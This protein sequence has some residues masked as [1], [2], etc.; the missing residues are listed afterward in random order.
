MGTAKGFS[1]VRRCTPAQTT[2]A[3]RNF[4]CRGGTQA[5]ANK[6]ISP[7]SPGATTA[8]TP[9]QTIY[10]TSESTINHIPGSNTHQEASSF[11]LLETT[12]EQAEKGQICKGRPP[13]VNSG[14]R[15]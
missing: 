9:A 6:E 15:D 4:A 10:P 5:A 12:S 11:E 2:T 7:P 8:S 13:G 1:G 14:L 3:F